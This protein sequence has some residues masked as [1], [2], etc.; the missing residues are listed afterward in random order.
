MYLSKP[1]NEVKHIKITKGKASLDKSTVKENFCKSSPK[2]GAINLIINGINISKIK[3]KI[4]KV[5]TRSEKILGKKF[6][7]SK[8]RFF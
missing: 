6:I 5:V 8:F 4:N 7:S 3:S 2:P 1:A